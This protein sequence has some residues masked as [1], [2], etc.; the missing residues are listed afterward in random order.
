MQC[1]LN[2]QF[3]KVNHSNYGLST[4]LLKNFAAICQTSRR[5]I[6]PEAVVGNEST[7]QTPPYSHLWGDNVS[8]EK[9]NEKKPLQI[10]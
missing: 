5:L 2:S 7:K 1:H 8:V 9:I 4:S 3:L 6:L 10:R